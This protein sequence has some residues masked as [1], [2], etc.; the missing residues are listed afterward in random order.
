[1]W[2]GLVH[3]TLSARGTVARA[4]T[5]LAERDRHA[6]LYPSRAF[7]ETADAGTVSAV[8]SGFGPARTWPAHGHPTG[9]RAL[10]P[11]EPVSGLTAG[12]RYCEHQQVLGVNQ[13]ED[14][15]RESTDERPPDLT[16]HRRFEFGEAR[17]TRN[18]RLDA[19]YELIAEAW[20]LALVPG[21]G[22]HQLGLS[23]RP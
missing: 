10:S 21:P 8:L 15:V 5:R 17:R 1:V 20:P 16:M 19:T 2:A 4:C 7:A 12:V 14:G 6:R 22:I 9:L 23:F 13:V 18:R 11:I 3:R